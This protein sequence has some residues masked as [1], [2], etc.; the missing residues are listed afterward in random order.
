MNPT[1]SPFHEIA[2][3]VHPLKNFPYFKK[4]INLVVVYINWLAIKRIKICELKAKKLF[5]C[6]A[7]SVEALPL[8]PGVRMLEIGCG[9]KS[10]TR[11][12]ATRIGH[13]L[14]IDRSSRAI[15]QA[16]HFHQMRLAS[17]R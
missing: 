7:A 1:F 6:I 15:Q 14:S 11:A 4:T 16:K 2:K 8:Y 3:L 13:I 5:S 9:P 10:A 17:G 12:I